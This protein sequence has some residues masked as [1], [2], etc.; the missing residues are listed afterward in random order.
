[1]GKRRGETGAVGF[2]SSKTTKRKTR[3]GGR[4]GEGE[5]R[6]ALETSAVQRGALRIERKE[7]HTHRERER[8]RERERDSEQ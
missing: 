8:E 7:W 4:E 3:E 5:R 2:S 1:M 6:G